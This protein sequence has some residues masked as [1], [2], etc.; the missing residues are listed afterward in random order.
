MVGDTAAGHH[1]ALVSEVDIFLL[2]S[3][4]ATHQKTAKIRAVI[5]MNGTVT[6]CSSVGWGIIMALLG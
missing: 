6:S 1:V 4:R 5:S 2:E 3:S